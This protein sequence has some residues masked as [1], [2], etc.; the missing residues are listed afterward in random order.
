MQWA[1]ANIDINSGRK[2]PMPNENKMQSSTHSNHKHLPNDGYL[3]EYMNCCINMRQERT[4][5]NEMKRKENSRVQRQATAIHN[6]NN[7]D[8]SKRRH[9]TDLWLLYVCSLPKTDS[10][11]F[12]YNNNMLRVLL[13]FVCMNQKILYGKVCL[14]LCISN[15]TV[16]TIHH[17][18][19]LLKSITSFIANIC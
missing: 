16:S 4:A 17:L 3:G 10:Q 11:F 7:R 1:I 6:N 8:A 2:R 9:S 12:F 13:P 19:K 15:S 14:H 5:K 18:Q